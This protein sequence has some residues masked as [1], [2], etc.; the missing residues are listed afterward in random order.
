MS[1]GSLLVIH[2]GALGDFLL[3]LPALWVLYG[4]LQPKRFA[5][6]GHPWVVEVLKGVPGIEVLD[7]NLPEASSLWRGGGSPLFGGFQVAA[8]FSKAAELREALLR[9]GTRQVLSL[10]PFPEDGQTHVMDHHIKNLYRLGF[11]AKISWPEVFLTDEEKR[12]A[13]EVLLAQGARPPFFVLHPGAGSPKKVWPPER[14]VEISRRLEALGLYSVVVEGPAD[15]EAV[16][17]FSAVHRGEELFLRCPPLR[18]LAAIL[19]E[20]SLY[21]G[22]D[23]GISHLAASVGTP[24]LVLFGPTDPALWSPRGPRVRW[25]WGRAPC[26]PCPAEQRRRCPRPLCMEA[27]GVEEVWAA[28]EELLQ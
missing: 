14:M 21:L 15:G 27:I 1:K 23:S 8:V 25:L 22:N 6:M 20:A 5:V 11:T 18:R 4:S 2:Q 28:L 12:Q 26:A 17:A 13:K 16:E 19:S 3:A 24:T 7:I 9:A 10:P